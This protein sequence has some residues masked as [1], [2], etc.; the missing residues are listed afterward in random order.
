MNTIPAFKLEPASCPTPGPSL[1]KADLD[2]LLRLYQV[3]LTARRMDEAEA[4]LVAR[5]AA[6]FH[7]SGAGHEGSAVFGGVPAA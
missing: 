1:S 6:L 2:R 7:V 4:A 5:G 3:I